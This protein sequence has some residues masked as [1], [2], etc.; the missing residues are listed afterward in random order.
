M[1]AISRCRRMNSPSGSVIGR[2]CHPLGRP[3]KPMRPVEDVTYG[4]ALGLLL[5]AAAPTNQ[6]WLHPSVLKEVIDTGG[7]SLARGFANFL[8]DVVRNGGRPSQVD[9]SAFDVGRTLAATR[10]RVVFRNDLIELL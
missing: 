1:C 6:L 4:F 9:R 3:S 8:E 7:Q 2:S 10:G 5:D